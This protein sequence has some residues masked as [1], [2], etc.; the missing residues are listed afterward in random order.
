[1]EVKGTQKQIINW[2]GRVNSQ[3]IGFNLYFFLNTSHGN[4]RTLNYFNW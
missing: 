4:Q 3:S 1:M 2:L